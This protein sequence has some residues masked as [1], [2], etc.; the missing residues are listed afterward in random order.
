MIRRPYTTACQFNTTGPPATIQWYFTPPNTPALGMSTAVVSLD[1]E[2]AKLAKFEVGEIPGAERGYKAFRTPPA[3]LG[4]HVCGTPNDFLHGGTYEP[5]LPR[6]IY[7]TNGLPLCC[8]PPRGVRGG[9]GAGGRGMVGHRWHDTPRG[10][11]TVG[12]AVVEDLAGIDRPRGGFTVGGPV[13]EVTSGVD[14]PAGGFA[15]GGPVV[16]ALAGVDVPAGGLEVGGSVVEELAGVD[17]PGGGLAVGGPVVEDLGGVDVP[18]GGLTLGGPVVEILARVDVPA[19]GF[20]VGGAVVEQ[21]AGVDVPGGGVR[22]GGAVVEQLGTTDYPGGVV[23]IDGG[24]LDYHSAMDTPSGGLILGGPITEVL[25]GGSDTPAQGMQI[26]GAVV[27]SYSN[28]PTPGASCATAATVSLGVTYSYTITGFG[29]NQWFTCVVPATGT[30]HI[31]TT[32]VNSSTVFLGGYEGG[33]CPLPNNIAFSTSGPPKWVW[34]T[35]V[36]GDVLR[37]EFS[38]F[39]AGSTAYTFNINTGP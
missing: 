2:E 36:A 1:W 9:A 37:I 19:G 17:V 31:T 35:A 5:F 39:A 11:L 13:V 28:Q 14:V 8:N 4:G 25:G 21:L 10:G 23:R 38:S 20:T 26:G 12:G 18:G 7:A 15:V 30:M 6:V 29:T 33:T 32:G 34:T 27:E 16:E 22:V 3:P 24:T